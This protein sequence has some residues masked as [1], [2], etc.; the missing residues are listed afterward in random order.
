M[1]LFTIFD[2]QIPA[3]VN[4]FPARSVGDAVRMC[5]F[6]IKEQRPFNSHPQHFTLFEVGA[7]DDI[8]GVVS[9]LTAPKQVLTFTEIQGVSS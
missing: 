9:G 2:S 1:K 8:S 3:H 6:L 4:P 7:I 5:Q